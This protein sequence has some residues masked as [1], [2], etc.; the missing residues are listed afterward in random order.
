MTPAPPGRRLEPPAHYDDERRATWTDTVARLKTMART[1]EGGDVFRADPNLIDVYV[2][3][4]AAHAQAAR[5]RSATN[6]MITRG[7]RAMENP[8]LAIQRRAAADIARIGRQLGLHRDPLAAP[9]AD[10]PL[11]AETSGRWCEEH[12]RRE[13]VHHRQSGGWCHQYRLIP[14]TGSCTKHV[15]MT[16]EQAREK[17]RVALARIYGGQ[18]VDIDPVAGLLEEVRRSAGVIRGLEGL[19]A[20]IEAE[21][22]GGWEPGSGGLWGGVTREVTGEDGTLVRERKAGQHVVLR[23]FNEER[24]HFVRACLAAKTAGAQQ[25]AIDTARALGAGVGRLLDAIFAALELNDYQRGLI[26]Q[27]VPVILRQYDPAGIAS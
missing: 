2:E 18:P 19:V 14:G 3:A 12:D 16:L 7:D 22:G 5:I 10:S 21:G 9:L 23:A 11:A 4:V 25:E 20:E 8:A 1:G 13:C 15:G 24:E 27:R 17:G 6:V 26:P